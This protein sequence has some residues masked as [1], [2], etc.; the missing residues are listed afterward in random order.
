M[1]DNEVKKP[2]AVLVGVD[3]DEYDFEESIAEL[4]ELTFAA[5]AE[6]IC[7]ITQNKD[8]LDKATVV[9]KG[10]L[11]EIADY[12]EKEHP[13]YVIFDHELTGSQLRNISDAINTDVLDRTMLIL[14]I[15]AKRAI[16]KEGKLQVELAQQQYRLPR[17]IGLGKSLSRQGGGIGSR[18]PGETKL[19]TDKRYI[20]SRINAL[21]DEIKQVEKTRILHRQ[22]RK[23]DGIQTAAIVGYTN[24]GKSTLLNTLTDAGV[25]SED[26]LFATLD[27]TARALLLP[28]GRQ[29]ML[30]DTVGLIRRLPHHLVEAF[31]STLE[32]AA[33]ADLILNVC[34][35]SSDQMQNQIDVTKTLLNSIGA[36]EIPVLNILS[37]ADKVE[38]PPTALND[39][40]VVISSLTGYGLSELLSKIS[41]KLKPTHKDMTLL[42]PYNKGSLLAEIRETGKIYTEEYQAEGTL[43]TANVDIKIINRVEQYEVKSDDKE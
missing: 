11:A 31:H 12:C 14:D 40:T 35:I 21:K 27:P 22:R 42:I 24:V 3:T 5:G 13:D 29:I 39:D 15:F 17:L 26:M 28:D 2:R 18:G 36:G 7:I 16:S 9:G 25:L 37:K 33:E 6:A 23:K 41:K 43:V 30:V 4:K 20:Q 10:K 32:E 8:S 1:F 34:D 19:E 38:N